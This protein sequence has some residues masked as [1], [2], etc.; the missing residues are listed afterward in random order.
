MRKVKSLGKETN[1][2]KST[3]SASRHSHLSQWESKVGNASLSLGMPINLLWRW[4]VLRVG[5][6]S[7]QNSNC[8]FLWDSKGELEQTT[9]PRRTAIVTFVRRLFPH[10]KTLKP[11]RLLFY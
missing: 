4:F 3:L 5:V 8:D 7:E 9:E 2:G 1:S 6:L 11:E 10:G